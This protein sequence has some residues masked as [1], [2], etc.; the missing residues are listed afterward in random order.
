MNGLKQNFLRPPATSGEYA[1]DA[2][3]VIGLL[4]VVAAA[5]WWEPT[6]AGIL[7]LALPALLVPRFVGVR[8]S[9]DIVYCLTVL[10]AAWSNVLD[11]YRTVAAWDLL[12]HVVCTGV[13]A[14]MLYFV[15]SRFGIVPAPG[16]APFRPRMAI[17]M[18]PALGLAVSALWE[19]IE[20]L[21]Y[22]FV[23][24]EIFVAYG[25]TIADMAVGG[26]GAVAAGIVVAFVRLER[27]TTESPSFSGRASP[28]RRA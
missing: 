17:A 13:I 16:S 27:A 9:F 10:V 1:A 19:M 12:L 18:V 21:G 6:D 20:W 26:L 7:A 23:S 8:S 3:R 24:D 4:S 22:T 2:L 28:V 25:D 15:F 11:L 14:A 5:I